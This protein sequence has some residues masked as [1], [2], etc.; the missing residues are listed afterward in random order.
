MHVLDLAQGWAYCLDLPDPFGSGP[1]EGHALAVSPDGGRLAVA[2]TSSGAVAYASASTL[3]IER[4]DRIP[5]RAAAAS[6]AYAPDGQRLLLG[7]GTAVTVLTPAAT[8]Q[9]RWP[10]PA[11]VRGLGFSRDGSRVYVGGA[12]EVRWLDAATGAVR[13]RAPVEG[14]T[15][16]RHV[17]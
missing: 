2:D 9:A 1:A 7:A 5:A 10:V 13:G 3:T 16:L 15:A 11:P 17:R 8:V 4:V 14:L 12:E 6:L